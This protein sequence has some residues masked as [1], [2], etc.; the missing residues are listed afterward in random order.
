MS[1]PDLIYKPRRPYDIDC[2]ALKD[3][4]ESDSDFFDNNR[5][6]ILHLLEPFEHSYG[7]ADK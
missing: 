6:L 2:P 7:S 1:A 4:E 5:D 3:Y